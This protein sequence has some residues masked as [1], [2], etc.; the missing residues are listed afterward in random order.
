MLCV[1]TLLWWHSVSTNV[2]LEDRVYLDR[3]LAAASVD[4]TRN[5]TDFAA[6]LA[7]IRAV[8]RT[9]LVVA[10]SYSGIPYNRQ[11]EPP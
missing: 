10:P 11:R 6:E 7:A 9:V 1:Q 5:R 8:Q 2:D 4:R 3:L